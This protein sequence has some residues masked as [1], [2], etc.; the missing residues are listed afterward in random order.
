[1]FA[2]LIG[3]YFGLGVVRSRDILISQIHSNSSAIEGREG[4]RERERERERESIP[5]SIVYVLDL[6]GLFETS[7]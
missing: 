7:I 5:E 3:K 1:M 6:I 2:Q 4:E